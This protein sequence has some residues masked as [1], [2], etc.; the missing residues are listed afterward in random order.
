MDNPTRGANSP[1]EGMAPL[2]HD[3]EQ[4]T[5]IMATD[6]AEVKRNT[7]VARTARRCAMGASGPLR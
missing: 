5:K 1:Y 6:I 2:A 4:L 3:R 7:T